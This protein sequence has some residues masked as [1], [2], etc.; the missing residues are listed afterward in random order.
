MN[1]HDEIEQKRAIM[2]VSPT[3]ENIK[4]FVKT[5]KE[6]LDSVFCD[7]GSDDPESKEYTIER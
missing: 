5:V 6:W 7:D 1:Y 2:K 3:V 4:E